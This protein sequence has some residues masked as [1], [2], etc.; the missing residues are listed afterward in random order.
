[1]GKELPLARGE[2]EGQPVLLASPSVRKFIYA[3]SSRDERTQEPS[4]SKGDEGGKAKDTKTKS[5]G[6]RKVKGAHAR[7]SESARR[8]RGNKNRKQGRGDEGEDKQ[9]RRSAQEL[10][11]TYPGSYCD[12]AETVP[13]YWVEVSKIDIGSLF[14]CRFCYRYLWLPLTTFDADNLGKL[15]NKFGHTEGY[16]R[17]LNRHRQAKLLIAKLHDLR[18]LETEIVDKMEFARIVDKIL[19]DK[20]YDKKEASN[21]K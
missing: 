21:A 13:H 10:G 15:M 2:E 7:Y 16:C 3:P 12:D 1:M 18:R 17:Y 8:R 4:P 19:S 5:K 9:I 11:I 14:Q 6:G 20:E